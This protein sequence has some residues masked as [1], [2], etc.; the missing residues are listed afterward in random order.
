[1]TLLEAMEARHS[2]RRFL[3]TPLT[4]ETI[5]ALER[6]IA[7]CNR[8]GNLQ[9]QLVTD[10]PDAF[11][12]RLAHYG[13][14]D[15]VQH[16][17]ALIGPKSADLDERIGYYGE[18]LVLLAQTLGLNTCWVALTFSK[19]ASKNHC[20]IAKN[21]R[22]VCV[23]ALGHGATAGTPH[24]SKALD[25]VCD[26]TDNMPEWYQRGLHYALLAPT[27]INQQKFRFSRQSNRVTVKPGVG[28]Y[29]KVDLGIVKYH[30]E[31]GAGRE[32]FRWL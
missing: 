10:A 11:D 28:F 18:R 7:V 14:F 22:L 15:N 3:S 21:E 12:S 19:S 13:K 17:I 32:N 26:D 16:F 8:E 23:L 1:M 20:Q 5:H 24:K 9:I 30:F 27:A 25:A 2:V 29:S 6:E 31:L 4:D